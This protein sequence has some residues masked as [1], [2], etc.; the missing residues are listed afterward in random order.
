MSD[1][2]YWLRVKLLLH[3]QHQDLQD[4]DGLGSCFFICMARAMFGNDDLHLDLRKLSVKPLR[5]PEIL[6]FLEKCLTQECGLADEDVIEEEKR[7][8][9]QNVVDRGQLESK[10]TWET[11]LDKFA[12]SPSMYAE[13][14]H[15]ASLM[16]LFNVEIKVYYTSPTKPT[17]LHWVTYQAKQVPEYVRTELG[18]IVKEF[19]P[20]I[21]SN[22]PLIELAKSRNHYQLV[23]PL[24]QRMIQGLSLSLSL[25]LCH[26]HTHT[27][28]LSLTHTFI[29]LY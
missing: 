12:L 2:E 8:I 19:G 24:K 3:E 21:M 17:S 20:H 5:D 11:Y 22:K 26:T 16:A 10:D 15:L 29:F 23:V 18:K 25:S 13:S 6:R 7:L 4:V 27:Y 28:T 9:L 14:Y 1:K